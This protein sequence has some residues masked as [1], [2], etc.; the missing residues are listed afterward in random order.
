MNLYVALLRGI[1]VGGKNLIKMTDLAAC[2]EAL[3]LTNVRT[4]I[5]SGNVIFRADQPDRARLT[6][7]LEDALSKTFQY[8]ASLVLRS[9][10]EMK[11]IV[12]HAP[13]GFGSQPA[14]YR[15]DVIFLKE[16]LTSSEAMQ[17]VTIKEGVDQA[18]SGKGVLYFSRLTSRA[19]QSRLTR[20]ISMPIYQ[21]MTIRNWNTTTKLLSMME[22]VNQ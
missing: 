13:T 18:F 20:I 21:S 1:N 8:N 4:Y 22:A 19:T 10:D 15:Y 14:T 17:S 11:D 6:G 12:A 3:G 2:F 9:D 7:W 5:Q 16:P